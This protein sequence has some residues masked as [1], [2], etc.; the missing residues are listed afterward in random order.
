M[1]LHR[2][3]LYIQLICNEARERIVLDLARDRG[4]EPNV[5]RVPDHLF[6]RLERS[7]QLVSVRKALEAAPFEQAQLPVI[8]S[9]Q[10]SDFREAH[11]PVQRVRRLGANAT[12]THLRV[13]GLVG[14]CAVLPPALAWRGRVPDSAVS[15]TTLCELTS[16]SRPR[17]SRP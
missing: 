4:H 6:P 7:F 13:H 3:L 5:H 9:C 17:C 14:G 10:L 15:S 11:T 1:N 8:L 2:H 16:R 12:G